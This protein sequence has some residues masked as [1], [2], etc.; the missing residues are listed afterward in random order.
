M[1]EPLQKISHADLGRNLKWYDAGLVIRRSTV[2]F[3]PKSAYTF[4][5]FV[6][7]NPLPIHPSGN[8]NNNNNNYYYYYYYY[9]Y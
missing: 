1:F 3:L 7:E 9:Y 6:F 8:N 2:R 4:Y 5:L